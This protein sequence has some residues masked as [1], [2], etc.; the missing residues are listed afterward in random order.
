MRFSQRLWLF[1]GVVLFTIGA[2][3]QFS[4]S[5]QGTVVDVA[6]AVIPKAA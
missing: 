4:H 3:A 2:H 1:L 5:V 6:G